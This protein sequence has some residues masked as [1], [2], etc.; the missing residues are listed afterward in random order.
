MFDHMY[1]ITFKSLLDS[2]ADSLA[3]CSVSVLVTL[4]P[5]SDKAVSS[6]DVHGDKMVEADQTHLYRTKHTC[7]IPSITIPHQIQL[8]LTNATITQ[9]TQL[10]HTNCN[11]TMRKIKLH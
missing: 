3:L 2:I 8:H 6:L 1:D 10:Y 4:L 9:R 5:Q 11:Y 7:T